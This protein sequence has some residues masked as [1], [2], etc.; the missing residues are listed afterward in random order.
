MPYLITK[1][2]PYIKPT[3]LDGEIS[4]IRAAKEGWVRKKKNPSAQTNKII[5]KALLMRG[6]VNKKRKNSK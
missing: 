6:K 3:V 2:M 1:F 5:E 4:A